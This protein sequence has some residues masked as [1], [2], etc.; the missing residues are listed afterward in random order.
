MARTKVSKAGQKRVSAKI[1]HL[2][3]T[4]PEMASKQRVAMAISMEKAHR[5]TKTG[6]YKKKGKK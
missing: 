6:V 3:H 5:L 2:A 4:E 1:S